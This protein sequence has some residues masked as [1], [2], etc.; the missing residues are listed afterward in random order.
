M[1]HKQSERFD[2]TKGCKVVDGVGF[3]IAKEGL[4]LEKADFEAFFCC[5]ESLSK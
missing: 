1:T 4:S 3:N 2:Q 5:N